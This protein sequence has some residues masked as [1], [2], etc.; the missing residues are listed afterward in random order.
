MLL[1]SGGTGQTL[2]SNFLFNYLKFICYISYVTPNLSKYLQAVWPVNIPVLDI[3]L[4]NDLDLSGCLPR[5]RPPATGVAGLGI[6][7][8]KPWI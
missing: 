1:N 5:P 4:Y 8:V 3:L 7:R 2:N 6:E